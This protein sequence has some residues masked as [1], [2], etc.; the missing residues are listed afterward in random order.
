MLEAL[1]QSRWMP[2]AVEVELL[3]ALPEQWADGSIEGVHIRGGAVID[4]R[5]KAGKLISMEVHAKSGGAIRLIPPQGQ[6]VA[7]IRTP[8]G[9]PLLGGKD[10]AIRLVSGTSYVIAFR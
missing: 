2:D 10:G 4:M 6:S 1:V 8:A 3:P 5:W 9:K 7:G